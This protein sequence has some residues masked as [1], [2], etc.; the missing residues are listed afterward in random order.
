MNKRQRKKRN[1]KVLKYA[2]ENS[3]P[4]VVREGDTFKICFTSKSEVGKWYP[5]YELMEIELK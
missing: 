1:K 2:Q 5:S 3:C 4:F